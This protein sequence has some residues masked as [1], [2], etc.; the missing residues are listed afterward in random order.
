MVRQFQESYFDSNY[1]STVQG[2]DAPSF[3]TVADAYGIKSHLISIKEDIPNLLKELSY[4]LREPTLIEVLIDTYTN[5]YPKLAFGKNFGDME[6]FVK[7][8]EMEST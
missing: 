7:P 4:P 5:A 3:T 6:P 8:I 2:Y 1:Q